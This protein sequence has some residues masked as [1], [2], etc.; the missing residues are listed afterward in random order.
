MTQIL[1]D[2]NPLEAETGANLLTVCLEAGIY[3]PHLCHLAQLPPAASCRLC[4]VAIEGT[5]HPVTACTVTVA[6]GLQVTTDTPEVRHLQRAALRL[7][8]SAHTIDCRHCPANRNC[9][10]QRIARFLRVPLRRPDLPAEPA[11]PPPFV[12][13]GILEVDAAHC[14]RC[15]R[16]VR[17]CRQLHGTA[18]LTF[19]GRGY[20]TVVTAWALPEDTDF[21][22]DC[23][24]CFEVCPV[25]AIRLRPADAEPA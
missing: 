16:C 12:P 17:L 3:I 9:E 6:P 7:L 8:L 4:F 1:V 25:A 24:A 19:A 21:C 5:A 10:L 15:G 18:R 22:R 11:A 2:G 13:G 20:D 23:Q 14:V